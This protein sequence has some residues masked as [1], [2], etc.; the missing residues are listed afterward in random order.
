VSDRI[1]PAQCRA[2]R[3][4]LGWSRFDLARES[5]VAAMV[6]AAAERGLRIPHE[7]TAG[8][9]RRVLEAAGVEFTNGK[10]P[11]VRMRDA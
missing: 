6:I 7:A 8:A 1:T 3:K 9:L 11:G 5:G 4:L 2:A 10:H